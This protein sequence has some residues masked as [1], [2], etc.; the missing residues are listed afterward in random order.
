VTISLTSAGREY[1][2]KKGYDADNGARPL[3]RLVQ[4]EIKRPL[5]DEILFGRLEKG[6]DVEVDVSGDQVKFKIVP[7]EDPLVT[8]H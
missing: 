8:V 5:A 1:F 6:G 7:A 2:A 4:D 3:A